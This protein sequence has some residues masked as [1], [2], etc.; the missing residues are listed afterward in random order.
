MR[1][2]TDESKE[3][4]VPSDNTWR[5][6]SEKK[7]IEMQTEYSHWNIKPPPYVQYPQKGN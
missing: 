6:K 2:V 7:I 3:K 1:P 4:S 5:K